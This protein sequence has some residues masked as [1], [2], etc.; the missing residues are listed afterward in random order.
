MRPNRKMAKN[1]IM[2]IECFLNRV[3]AL[4]Y[5]IEAFVKLFSSGEILP[6]WRHISVESQTFRIE[7]ECEPEVP[8]DN[9]GCQI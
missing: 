5:Q 8:F 4:I 9:L 1:V 6:H 2:W 7:P 3:D